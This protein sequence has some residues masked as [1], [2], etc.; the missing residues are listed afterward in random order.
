M[1]SAEI[2]ASWT[3]P[4]SQ[5]VARWPDML[6][7]AVAVALNGPGLEATVLSMQAGG[8]NGVHEIEIEAEEDGIT[9]QRTI[10]FDAS[11]QTSH[12]VA[13]MLLTELARAN[14]RWRGV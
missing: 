11:S 7:S 13:R 8:T 4:L 3:G 6:N 2:E 12:P 9:W 14:R 10:R 5:A 1:R